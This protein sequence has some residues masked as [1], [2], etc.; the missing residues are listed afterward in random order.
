MTN[1]QLL[2]KTLKIIKQKFNAAIAK[3]S[4]DNQ[5]INC[6]LKS[7][8]FFLK[9]SYPISRI[10]YTPMVA[11]IPH[12]NSGMYI[13]AFQFVVNNGASI[14]IY[15]NT[16]SAIL[17]GKILNSSFCVNIDSCKAVVKDHTHSPIVPVCV[18]R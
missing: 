13:L 14:I 15:H 6:L 11:K 7:I 12:T 3:L 5:F 2:L 1:A 18:S 17:T 10:N 8:Y 9:M 16:G 4:I